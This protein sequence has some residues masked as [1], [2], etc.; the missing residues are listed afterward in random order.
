VTIGANSYDYTANV[1]STGA[2][3]LSVAITS[4]NTAA[5]SSDVFQGA[6]Q[7]LPQYWTTYGGQIYYT[8]N[9]SADYDGKNLYMDY[10][11][12]QTRITSDNQSLI[13]PD[14]V[15][16]VNYLCW[17]FLKKLNNGEETESSLAYMN[18]F[19]KRLEKMKQK[20]TLG[21]TFKLKPRL[22]NFA[23]QSQFDEDTPRYIRDAGFPSTG[24]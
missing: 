22:Q 8:P 18:Q 13:I 16:A 11:I 6:S 5:I 24:F 2:L 14:S 3:T 17:K 7:G 12:A 21:K 9:T 15:V 4:A 23:T 19:L 20:E 10:Y 1:T